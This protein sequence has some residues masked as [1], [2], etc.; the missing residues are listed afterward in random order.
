MK[1]RWAK[2]TNF[3]PQDE[4]V[5][6]FHSVTRG[7]SKI[8]KEDFDRINEVLV[9]EE[10][11]DEIKKVIAELYVDKFIVKMDEN[12]KKMFK[13]A[14]ASRNDSGECVTYFIPTFACNFRCPYCIVDSTEH[15][16]ENKKKGLSE[17]ETIFVA[18][19][20]KDYV[21]NNN[22]KK[23]TIELF[24]GEPLVGF[25]QNIIFLKEIMSLKEQGIEVVVNMISNCYLLTEEKLD[26]LVECGLTSIQCTID[27]PKEI[28]DQRRI[29]A[30]GNGSF[31]KIIENISMLKS[32]NVPLII[33]IN[34][35]KDNAPYVDELIEYLAEKGFNRSATIGVAPVDPPVIDSKISG[36]TME[37]MQ[38]LQPIY[39]SLRKNKFKF[40]LW[41][42][43]CGH[44]LRDFFVICPDGSLYNCP[45]F[46]GMKNYEVGNVFNG[47]F[48]DKR[49]VVH[50]IPDRCY[51]C[52]LVGVCSGGC[53]FTKTVHHLGDEYCLKMT[54]SEMVK[55]YM[56]NMYS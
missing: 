17:E 15:S 44:G 46:A 8:A 56:Y 5:I 38:Y 6:L 55:Q 4:S 14:R 11:T 12:E 10:P 47:G 35:D 13:M 9:G 22:L 28:H 51:D 34:I 53:Y 52:S 31:D 39:A 36:H 29:L 24:G 40:K 23:L 1:I 49:P 41:E 18:S 21:L 43:F 54:H 42:T 45:S 26:K 27:G 16:V 20:L 25:K 7:V 32:K 19:W 50:E 30:N 2:Y 48:Y 33:R 3:Y 37:T